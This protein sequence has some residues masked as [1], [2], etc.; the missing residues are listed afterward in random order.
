MKDW[1]EAADFVGYIMFFVAI[2]FVIQAFYI[3]ILSMQM[4]RRYASLD[5]ASISDVLEEFNQAKMSPLNMF[6]MRFRLI[7][8]LQVMKNVEFKIGWSV[9][10]DTYELPSRFDYVEYI[11]R[12]LKR[13]ALRL[14]NIHTSSWLFVFVLVLLNYGRMWAFDKKCRSGFSLDEREDPDEETY[15]ECEEMHRTMFQLSGF[16][17]VVYII[18]LYVLGRIYTFRIIAR[19][20]VLSV[21]DY[22]NFLI[23]EE[24]TLVSN[25]QRK[26][27]IENPNRRNSLTTFRSSMN[28][29]LL[30]Q[31]KIK[32]EKAEVI[33]KN[34]MWIR[35]AHKFSYKLRPASHRGIARVGT[36]SF[37]ESRQELDITQ[38]D[39]LGSNS[40]EDASGAKV[41]STSEDANDTTKQSTGQLMRT[42]AATGAMKLKVQRNHLPSM[43]E[44][45]KSQ[46]SMFSEDLSEIFL[47]NSPNLYFK[48]VEIGILMNSLYAAVWVCNYMTN[49]SFGFE[50]SL[51][52]I[53]PLLVC[54]PVI[55][56]VVK[57]ASL[58]DCTATLHMD[59]V[60]SIIEDLEAGE[61]L[62]KSIKRKMSRLNIAEEDVIASVDKLF[63][64]LASANS[65]N[66]IAAGDFRQILGSLNIH[67]RY[68]KFDIIVTSSIFAIW[69]YFGNVN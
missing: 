15:H 54:L 57:I 59:V 36:S 64:K 7:P 53:I 46:N 49:S 22:E 48:S 5:K 58:I 34:S 21:S 25:E 52:F 1:L 4:K 28:K 2:F 45:Q 43:K 16:F 27:A 65:P 19:A 68:V 30:Q 32:K 20:G 6:L 67:F 41:H 60:A 38:K 44:K 62:K 10:R 42:D 61:N 56:E 39:H 69:Y 51:L 40:F 14:V 50:T 13:F 8:T 23:F 63:S 33:S 29:Y 55:G 17:I 11:S 37:D 9:F 47:F 18:S 24:S 26:L 31:A 12:C 3:M 66:A 35:V